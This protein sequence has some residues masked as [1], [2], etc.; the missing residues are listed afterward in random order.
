[1]HVPYP[2][3]VIDNYRAAIRGEDPSY[4]HLAHLGGRPIGLFQHYRIG[5]DPDYASA[6]ALAEDAIGVDLFIG[7]P[8]IIGK[9]H[10]PALLRAYLRDVA[11]PFHG[12]EVCVIGP[13]AS[14]TSAIRAYEKAGFTFLRVARV[15]DEPEPEHLM[16]LLRST[17]R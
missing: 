7:E 16:R 3:A 9:G 5:D 1:M 8:D 17:L 15:P 6:L 14:N 13:S 10:G 11:F 2:D 4:H 12:L